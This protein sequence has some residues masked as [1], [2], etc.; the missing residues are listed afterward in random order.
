[1]G[2][3]FLFSVVHNPCSQLH[4]HLWLSAHAM[5][6]AVGTWQMA[7]VPCHYHIPISDSVV[8]VSM[9]LSKISLTIHWL[10]NSC[11]FAHSPP[12]STHSSISFF[13]CCGASVIFNN[14][15]HSFPSSYACLMY[16]EP[17]HINSVAF[18]VCVCSHHATV[19]VSPSQ[20]LLCRSRA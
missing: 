3:P 5:G 16:A 17:R 15:I 8:N 2:R 9:K 11:F 12:H 13:L 10:S 19:F 7:G 20:Y 14:E 18:N 6:R 4:L 1:V